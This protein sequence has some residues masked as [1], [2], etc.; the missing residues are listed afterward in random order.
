MAFKITIDTEKCIGCGAC[1]SVCENFEITEG[2]AHVKNDTVEE[3][4]CNREAANSCP[5]QCIKVEEI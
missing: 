5:V 3:E 2:K 4:G 1:A